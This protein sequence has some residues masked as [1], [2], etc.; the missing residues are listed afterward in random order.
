MNSAIFWRLV[1]K[2]YRQ[3][4]SLWIAI[5]L[6]GLIFQVAMLV[7][8]SL[9]GIT[10]LPEKLFTIA[11]SVPVLYSLGCGATLFAGEH[12]SETF[13]F[14]QSLPVSSGHVF[15]AKF[16][17]AVISGLL[18]FPILWLLAFAMTSW[19]L[20]EAN[21]HLQLWGGGIVATIEVLIWAVLGS[22]LIRR[23]LPAAIA[24]GVAAGLLGYGSL[25][26][27][28]VLERTIGQRANE[29]IATLPLRMCFALLAFVISIKLGRQWFS[30]HPMRWRSSARRRLRLG[31]A[32]AQR[33]TP[34]TT[35]TIFARLVWHQWRQCRATMLWCIAGYVVLCTWFTLTQD[36]GDAFLGL[37]PA[38]ATIFGASVFAADQRQERYQFFTEHGVRPRLMWWSRQAV[39]GVA[40]AV[41]AIFAFTLLVSE[42]WRAS[43]RHQTLFEF[44]LYSVLAF[45][46]GQI[47]SILIRSAI[48]AIFTAV[49]STILLGLWVAFT[50]RLGIIWIF[51]ALPLMLVMFWASWLYAPK[52]IQQRYT[53]RVRITTAATIIVPLIGIVAG[54]AA[55]R[56]YE[57]PA[58]EP[59]FNPTLPEY[60]RSPAARETA[61]MYEKAKGLLRNR[62]GVSE[63]GATNVA[64]RDDQ[65][66]QGLDTFLAATKRQTCRFYHWDDDATGKLFDGQ[67]LTQNVIAE[68]KARID[69]GDVDG[70]WE[71]YVGVLQ[72]AAHFYQQQSEAA[73]RIAG[74]NTE[75]KLY[76]ALPAWADHESLTPE[77]LRDAVI[78]LQTWSNNNAIDWEQSVLEHRYNSQQ[79]LALDERV[80]KVHY[81]FDA[82]N[83]AAMKTLGVLLPWERARMVRLLDIYTE[84]ELQGIRM[85][86][87]RGPRIPPH[88][89]ATLPWDVQLTLKNGERKLIRSTESEMWM[90]TSLWLSST[91]PQ[92][93]AN[94]V[95][96]EQEYQVRRNAVQQQLALIAW[97]KQHERLPDTLRELKGSP[98]D[99]LPL[100]PYT[101]QPFVYFPNGVDEEV[102]DDGYIGIGGMMM[103]G[104]G[105]GM[106][107]AAGTDDAEWKPPKP[108]LV[109]SEPFLW[110]PGKGLRYAPASSRVLSDSPMAGDF[111]DQ[112]G[113]TLTD[114]NLLHQGLRYPI[115]T[116]EQPETK[117]QPSDS[118]DN[119]D[120]LPAGE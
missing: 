26:V 107:S 63:N 31:A 99:N 88:S 28:I 51:S 52:W 97:R 8:C 4:Q 22:L 6:A 111:R 86:R 60:D 7:Y 102:W 29:Y 25:V 114:T 80:M 96:W 38:L 2:E 83:R 94:Y 64:P 74:M 30:E 44:V 20:P 56:V 90:L 93:A 62:L 43:S 87:E 37:L 34:T 40:L 57:I 113:N 32:S 1:W 19:T 79:V 71:L 3:Q 112:S 16:A 12:E 11:L 13:S 75:E 23:V 76:A 69:E 84:T 91:S 21:W 100:D 24:G 89:Q 95:A 5:A 50:Q 65:W 42:E 59:S 81:E 98:F 39:W 9:Y 104:F 35:F 106:E 46:A 36:G 118:S 82:T 14:Q 77:R 18:L 101:N 115:P 73:Y 58:I 116:L 17:F 61:A 78:E 33:T 47:C 117:Q 53:W 108:K 85:I 54:T 49:F 15:R 68:A 48:V 27:T 55:Y 110:S 103:G 66:Q 10:G 109:R 72:L 67:Q 92:F 70:A 41:I 120:A 119:A 45:S 105:E